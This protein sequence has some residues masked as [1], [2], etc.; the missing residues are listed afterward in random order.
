M[1]AELLPDGGIDCPT[2]RLFG[3]PDYPCYDETCGCSDCERIRAE[4]D[5]LHVLGA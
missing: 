4:L 3:V 5:E 1:T 2:C